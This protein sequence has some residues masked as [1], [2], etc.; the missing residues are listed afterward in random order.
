MQVLLTIFE[1]SAK[2]SKILEINKPTKCTIYEKSGNLVHFSK[3]GNWPFSWTF[4]EFCHNICAKCLILEI[5]VLIEKHLGLY[6]D[7]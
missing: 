4:K 3:K 5:L 7:N 2:I 6:E 1:I